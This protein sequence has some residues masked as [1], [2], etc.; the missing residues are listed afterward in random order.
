MNFN[1]NSAMENL[2]EDTQHILL[3]AFED[4]YAQESEV[5]ISAL[6]ESREELKNSMLE[7][8]VE[9]DKYKDE[10]MRVSAGK[11]ENSHRKKGIL[12]LVKEIKSKSSRLYLS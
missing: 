4:F 7:L 10:L 1:D 2:D 11:F 6:N 9:Q 5:M 8:C 12:I 3:R